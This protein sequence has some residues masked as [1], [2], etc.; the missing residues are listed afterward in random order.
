MRFQWFQRNKKK[1]RKKVIVRETFFRGLQCEQRDNCVSRLHCSACFFRAGLSA[2]SAV[3]SEQK[4]K[5]KKKVGGS[6]EP[7]PLPL[8][9]QGHVVTL[10]GSQ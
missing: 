9:G 7:Q 5:K 8:H 10:S 2:R 1:E 4:K 3:P 6:N